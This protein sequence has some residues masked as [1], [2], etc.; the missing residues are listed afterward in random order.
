MQTIKNYNSLWD[1]EIDR[2]LTLLKSNQIAFKY[3]RKYE[4]NFDTDKKLHMSCDCGG[5]IQ[6]IVSQTNNEILQTI[7]DQQPNRSVPYFY[8]HYLIK[9]IESEKIPFEFCE[10]EKADKYQMFVYMKGKTQK[11]KHNY[12][13][14][15]IITDALKCLDSR[16]I[17]FNML[18][19]D[20]HSGILVEPVTLDAQNK[21]IIY[22]DMTSN[23]EWCRFIRSKVY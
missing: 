13:H 16:K 5:L 17:H 2:F 19:A 9:L 18:H 20:I 22:N 7:L 14:I 12:Y 23:Y 8:I 3:L 21:K 11:N 6:Y 1:V 10:P 4:V 15:G